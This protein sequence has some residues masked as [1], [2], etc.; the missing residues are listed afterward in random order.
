MT[1]GARQRRTSRSVTL[2]LCATLAL[3]GCSS[4][5]DKSSGSATSSASPSASTTTRAVTASKS[6]TR[7]RPPAAP[8]PTRGPAGQKKFA[9]YVMLLWGYALRTNDAAAL[10]ALSAPG[11]KCQGCKVFAASLKKRKKQGW[12]VDFPGVTV[13]KVT[14]KPVDDNVYAKATVDVPRSDSYNSDGSFRNTNQAHRGATFEV[15][16]HRGA[17]RFQLLAFTVS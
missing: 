1:T 17:K 9:R 11:E 5:S 4:G 14:V 3:G 2:A 7:T 15:L 10:T 6:P 16:M 13:R 12:Y 8:A